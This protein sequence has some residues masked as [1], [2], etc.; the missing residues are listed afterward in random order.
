[1]N[2]LSNIMYPSFDYPSEARRLI[3]CDFDETYMPYSDK[4]KKESGI[5]ELEIFVDNNCQR[6]G[7]L[8]GWV[9]GS[10]LAAVLRKSQGYVNRFPHFIATSLGSELYWVNDNQIQVSDEW[11]KLIQESGFK[12]ENIRELVCSLRD[13]GISLPKQVEDYQGKNMESYYYFLSDNSKNDLLHIEELASECNIKALITKCNPAAGDPENC[14]DVQFLPMC[15]GKKEILNFLINSL[16]I[17]IEN[18]WAF[19]DSFNDYEILNE[20]RNPYIVANADP[21]LKEMIPHAVLNHKYS[22]GIKEALKNIQ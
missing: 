5:N 22:H 6:L 21:T 19:G 11:E 8:L 17:D 2:T 13:K 20:V 18:T 16:H 9:T 7:L 4:D 12:K 3:I 15:C 1:M 10:S 14:F